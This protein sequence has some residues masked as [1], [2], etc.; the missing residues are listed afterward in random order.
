M[1]VLHVIADLGTYGAER[2][3]ALLLNNLR[4]PELELAVMTVYSSPEAAAGLAVPVLDAARRGRYDIAF[5]PRMIGLMRAWKPDVVHTH[6]HMGKYW[7]RIAAL[8][9]GVETIVHTE[10]NSE[11][12]APGLY[13][14]PN[15]VLVPRTDA[16]VAFS[17]THRSALAAD[18][19]IPLDRIVV[20]PNGIELAKIARDERERARAALG[21]RPGEPVLMHVGRISPVKNQRLAIETLARLAAP[22]RLVFVGDGNGRAAL[23]SLARSRGVADRVTFLGFRDDAATL[24]AG[25]DIAL[26]TSHNEAM[27][28]A[29]IEAMVAGAP[30]VST[31]WHGAREMLGNGAFGVV[32]PDYT[33]AALANAVRAVL[34]DPAAAHDRAARARAFAGQ[35][36]DIA[37]TARRH[38]ALYRDLSARTRSASRVITAARS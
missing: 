29:V 3:L 24:V 5:L 13:R 31:P 21:A 32:A 34:D 26:V 1:R 9:S 25:A 8:A 33:P 7:G 6:M 20:I 12:G 11:F 27:P 16:V 15:R 23:E 17:Q 38:A 30:L 19:A 22:A 28:L 35:E 36:Y 37:T 14:I 18:E 2:L 10:H 4:D